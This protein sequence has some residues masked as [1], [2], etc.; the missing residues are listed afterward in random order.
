[1]RVR[2]FPKLPGLP[3]SVLGFGC[4]RLPVQPEDPHKVDEDL[5]IAL[6]R[7]AIEEGVNYLDT[8]Y[9]YHGGA[10]EEVVGHALR[11]GYRTRVQLADKAPVW[12]VERPSDWERLLEL[13]LKRLKVSSI[14]FYFLHALNREG[15]AT[16]QAQGAFKALER[17]MADGRIRH[18]GFSFHDA[19]DLFREIVDA[20]DW[21]CCMLQH[22]FLDEGFQAGTPGLHLAAQRGIG[23]IAMEPLRG[24]ALAQVPEPVVRMWARADPSRTPAQWALR[25]LWNKPE[26]TLVLSGMNRPHQL[27]ENLA[28]ACRAE[29]NALSEAELALFREVRAWY[30]QRMAA[31]CT[32]CGYCEPCPEG[33]AI[34]EVLTQLN[35]ATMFDAPAQASAAYRAFVVGAGHGGDRCTACGQCMPRCPQGLDIPTLMSETHARLGG[36]H[37]FIP[38]VGM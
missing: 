5:A 10:S 31:P 34:P 23:I 13:Q 14:D 33:V 18:L 32:T 22:N 1:M 17:A 2:T 38:G 3:L 29:A 9:L 12:L 8:A 20:Y 21:T 26:V 7:Q 35:H 11:D 6:I 19:P 36:G 30:E 15:W 24:G 27:E 25:W 28:E 16:V 37:E 4:M